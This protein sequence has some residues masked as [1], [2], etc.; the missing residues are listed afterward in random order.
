MRKR[1]LDDG[2]GGWVLVDNAG[3]QPR[4]A[5]EIDTLLHP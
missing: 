3:Y 2:K 5:A 1:V 4:S